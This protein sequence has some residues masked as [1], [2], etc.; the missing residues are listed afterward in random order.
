MFL[1][2]IF[3]IICVILRTIKRLYSILAVKLTTKTNKNF[4]VLGTESI[5]NVHVTFAFKNM[6]F[7]QWLGP[8]GS[9]SVKAWTPNGKS[10]EQKSET[11]IATFSGLD[12]TKPYY[13][14]I[15]P[16][17]ITSG[18]C[19]PEEVLAGMFYMHAKGNL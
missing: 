8:Q 1:C 11:W 15:K 10:W 14:S 16:V 19:R 7:V 6:M 4:F 9:Y 5:R 3:F 2:T 12:D 18:A 13:I 17:S